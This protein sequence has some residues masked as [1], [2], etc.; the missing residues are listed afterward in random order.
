MRLQLSV[1][2]TRL[3]SSGKDETEREHRELGPISRRQ[4]FMHGQ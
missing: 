1:I 4:I 2:T 3:S